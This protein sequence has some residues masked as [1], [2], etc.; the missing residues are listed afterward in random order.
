M[1]IIIIIIKFAC[2][3]CNWIIIILLLFVFSYSC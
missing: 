2:K 1:I 3:N